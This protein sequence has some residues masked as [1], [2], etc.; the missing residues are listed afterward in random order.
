MIYSF[1]V[2]NVRHPVNDGIQPMTNGAIR[3]TI[4]ITIVAFD[5]RE[6]TFDKCDFVRYVIKLESFIVQSKECF[7]HSAT[8]VV[9]LV[10]GRGSRHSQLVT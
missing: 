6:S 4:S 1:G 9:Q 7:T 2:H 5:F 10:D 3:F 8:M